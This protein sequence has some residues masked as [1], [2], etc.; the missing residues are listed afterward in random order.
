[1]I[2]KPDPEPYVK[3]A[4]LYSFAPEDCVVVEDAPAGIR[5][6]KAAGTRI[7]SS[8]PKPTT[9]SSNWGLAGS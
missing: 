7:C 8:T 5:S 3:G 9:S 4:A 1:M 6:G 2:G